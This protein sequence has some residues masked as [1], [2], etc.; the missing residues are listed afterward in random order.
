M[1][2]TR[3]EERAANDGAGAAST[4]NGPS[5]HRGSAGLRQQTRLPPNSAAAAAAPA[6]SPAA[7]GAAGA[8]GRS[9]GQG[10]S[11]PR[12]KDADRQEWIRLDDDNVQ[13]EW[14]RCA[15][16]QAMSPSAKAAA[17][18]WQQSR[19]QYHNVLPLSP[20]LPP[21]PHAPGEPCNCSVSY[22]QMMGNFGLGSPSIVRLRCRPPP[23]P[24]CSL[25]AHCS[26]VALFFLFLTRFRLRAP[27]LRSG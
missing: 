19:K 21:L 20:L 4:H 24:L 25:P 3:G 7:A 8:A 12:R 6:A 11:R 27:A 18:A 13:Q 22:C 17:C 1:V 16:E 10:V 5:T 23:P 26:A 9:Y 15:H 2:A 14:L